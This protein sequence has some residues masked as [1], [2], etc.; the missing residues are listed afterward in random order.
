M[1]NRIAHNA[2]IRFFAQNPVAK[3][4]FELFDALPHVVFYAKDLESRFVGVNQSFLKHHGL[5]N[6]LEAI[7]KDDRDF[8]PLVMAEAYRE[9]DRRVLQSGQVLPG[10]VWLVHQQRKWPRWYVSTKTP[11]FDPTSKV[12]G[13]AGAMYP[14]EAPEERRELFQ[15]L[16]PVVQHIE[17]H[18]ASS[19][20]MSE[21]AALAGLS[22]THFN[23][24]FQKLL[25]MTPSQ[26]LRTVRVQAAE[27]LLLNT[28]RSLSEIAAEV[29]YADQSHLTR[30][31]RKQTGM[32]PAAFRRRYRME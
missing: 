25:R 11:L 12:V 24:Q 20:S 10:Q 2:K 4:L 9:E 13:L 16:T 14:V 7:G 3:S 30:E 28:S 18:F 5:K 1:P 26:Y 21:M 27:R 32:T 29:G 23:R 6:E 8:H 31:F 22:A 19:I 15:E 17:Q